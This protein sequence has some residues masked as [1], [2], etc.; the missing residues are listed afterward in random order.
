MPDV[1]LV[2]K[3]LLR[4]MPALGR[5][6]A[7]VDVWLLK[8]AFGLLGA[9]P[10]RSAAG[11]AAGLFGLVGP[12]GPQGEKVRRNLRIVFPRC[13]DTELRRLTRATF[14]H[15]GVATAELVHARHVIAA[16]ETRIE[17]LTED[18]AIP[19]LRP[20]A[21]AVI[22]TAHV[23]AWQYVAMLG[24]LAGVRLTS[25]YAPELNP[26]V[27][28]LFLDLREAM[29]CRW[30]SRDDSAKPLLR[31]LAAGNCVGFATDTRFDQGRM[32][33]FCG[34]EAMTNTAA[35]RLALRYN[36]PLI[37]VRCDR[38]PG[39]RYRMVLTRLISPDPA[40]ASADE[41]ALGMTREMN[42]EFE[43]WI[44]ETP[45][46]W[47]CMK[48]RWPRNLTAGDAAGAAEPAPVPQPGA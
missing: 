25:L 9:L 23:G 36:C 29:G 37:T 2:P 11:L 5:V 8:A 24:Q 27:R 34:H 13:N 45:G 10:Q 1:Y 39:E 22:V 38:L 46:Q 40:C 6:L 21:P 47:V 26:L 35:A 18:A 43:R 33:S 48:R 4:A 17:M 20:G 19:P 44:R 15:M 42:L 16:R 12:A 3:R 14:R 28:P 32:V 30:L 7:H 41:Q 31:E